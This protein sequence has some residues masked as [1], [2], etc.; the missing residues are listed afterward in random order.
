MML[1]VDRR[2]LIVGAVALAVACSAALAFRF[3]GGNKP[4]GP[5]LARIVHGER[6][7]AIGAGTEPTVERAFDE[8]RV[9]TE[10]NV[11]KPL[12][13]PPQPAVALAVPAE[14]PSPTASQRRPSGTPPRR[15]D[16]TADL[17]MTGVVESDSGL[18]VLI[19]D[20]R[21]GTSVYA[22]IGDLVFGLR[23]AGI[24]AKRVAL[25]QGDETYM[26]AMGTK[27]IPQEGERVA[28]AAV[29]PGASSSASGGGEAGGP[30]RPGFGGPPGFG[31]RG[32]SREEM[33]RRFGGM[34][35][36]GGEGFGGGYGSRG[37][38]GGYSGRGRG[39]GGR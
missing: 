25:T 38:G 22:G 33:M 32:M 27:E 17:A 34:R 19:N 31:F 3:I 28:S 11:F 35:P 37:Y 15:R 29:G 20:I 4:A 30:P 12:L 24:E 36:G 16:P 8:Y 13:T 5:P 7:D 9:V 1:R 2:T 39:G 21:S 26:L 10:R 6:A 18:L 23:V 14:I